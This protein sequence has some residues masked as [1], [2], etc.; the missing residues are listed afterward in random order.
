MA[1]TVLIVHTLFEILGGGELLALSMA[2]ALSQ[3]GYDV[4]VLTFTRVD[5]DVLR[6]LFN[7]TFRVRVEERGSLLNS[8]LYRYTS[9]RAVRLRRLI[10]YSRL[11]GELE[12]YRE[13]YDVVVETQSN[14]PA[15]V[16]IS[17]IHFPA[18]L[19]PPG[20]SGR[21]YEILV[22]HYV[23]K[24]EK[25]GR[26]GLVLTNSKWTAKHVY[27]AYG[28]VPL[29][30]YPPVDVE[31]FS[32]A[33]DG[34][35][36]ENLVVTVSRFTP[37]KRLGEICVAAKL[38]RDY[39]FVIAGSMSEYSH[40]TVEAVRA[41]CNEL[42]VRNVVL[43]PN[44][45]RGQLLELMER[46]KYYLHPPFPEHFGI[47]VV[48]AMAAGLIPIVYRGGG[49]WH[50]VVKDVS[51][52]L[53]YNDVSDVARIIGVLERHPGM[54]GKLRSKAIERSRLFAYER[55]RREISRIVDYV[56]EVKSPW[57]G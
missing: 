12:E 2:R 4:E 26:A 3:S 47:A 11:L 36:D 51:P 14:L 55:F 35:H 5:S 32:R 31:Y 15:P 18:K 23:K 37:E 13:S 21:L 10:L 16:D 44:L 54:A 7:T 8:L 56:Y 46:A 17:Y 27:R 29:V 20:G 38:L 41:R 52:I 34:P 9:G 48:E 24:I 40:K 43:K 28:V 49:A 1:K 19:S 30:V 57:G 50:D 39:I 33:V 42:G 22:N 53:G 25:R 6:R 45:P